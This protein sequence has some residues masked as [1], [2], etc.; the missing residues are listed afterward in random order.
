MTLSKKDSFLNFDGVLF[1][2]LI[3]ALV[4]GQLNLLPEEINKNILI[5]TGSIATI[6]VFL[7]AVKAIIKKRASIDL[8]ASIALIISLIEKE[9]FSIVFINLMITSARIFANYA[10]L[11]SRSAIQTLM[12]LKPNKAVVERNGK[13]IEVPLEQIKAGDR[14]IVGIGEKVPIDGSVIAGE[15]TIDQSS[16]TGESVPVFKKEKD[17]VLSSTV[18]ISGNIVIKAEKIGKDTAFE[19][20]ISLV[21]K[22]QANKAEIETI[23]DKFSKWYIGATILGSAIIYLFSRDVNFVLA[24]LLVSCADDVAIAVPMALTA[25]ITNSARRGA[26]IK[27]GNF[28]ENLSKLKIIIFDKTGTLTQGKLTV[29]KILTFNNELPEK[30]LEIAGALCSFSHHPIA[31]AINSCVLDKKIIFKG[32]QEFEERPGKGMTA[33]Y[34]KEK[35]MV[36]SLSFFEESK[37][38]TTASQLKQ[39]TEEINQGYNATLVSK[40]KK[41]I[42]AIILGDALRPNIKDTIAKLKESGIEKIVM[43]TGD[44]EKAAQKIAKELGIHEYHAN[45]LPEQKTDYL[46]KYINKKYKVA[47]VGD[48]V[49]DAPCLA[50]ADIGIA[51]GAI[52]SDAA[53]ESADIAIMKDDLS[54]IPELIKLGRRT[55]NVIKQ[56][57]AIWAGINIVGFVLVGIAV[58]DPTGAAAYN[59]T[60]D[61][62]PIFNSLRLFK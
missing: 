16:L 1:I 24:L 25:A 36:G 43:L 6:P 38:E 56:D 62:I 39:I 57:M 3:A 54:Q 4:I 9:W 13:A 2:A 42:G 44:N 12:K 59:F 20:I 18:V 31:H 49:N 34:E 33:R 10:E 15:A 60:T 5:F 55:M 52:G 28:I 58:L 14:V 48:G 19:K 7:N 50:L 32:P 46:K 26:I 40:G 8:L 45:L 47:M 41:I 29:E 22:S 21:E 35:I 17:R 27:G 30:I 23:S 51:M 61:F 11:K 37:I 53:I